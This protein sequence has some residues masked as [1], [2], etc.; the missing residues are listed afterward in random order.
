MSTKLKFKKDPEIKMGAA[1]KLAAD[2]A[3]QAGIKVEDAIA[4]L[5]Q[6]GYF[7]IH[8]ANRYAKSDKGKR[9]VARAHKDQVKVRSK[10]RKVARAKAKPAPPKRPAVKRVSKPVTVR[11]PKAPTIQYGSAAYSKA[12]E[13]QAT[14]NAA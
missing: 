1:R 7:R 14:A 6:T 5:I 8:A 3:K 4:R 10:D 12:V 2:Y 13:E 9:A 11:K